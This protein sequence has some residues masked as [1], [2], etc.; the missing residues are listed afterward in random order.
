MLGRSKSPKLGGGRRKLDANLRESAVGSAQARHA[1]FGF[2]L[3]F[4]ISQEKF[5]SDGHFGGENHQSTIVADRD[6]EGLLLEGLLL[7]RFPAD[8]QR[9]VQQIALTASAFGASCCVECVRSYRLWIWHSRSLAGT[10][11]EAWLA[12]P[13][14]RCSIQR[15]PC[16]CKSILV[17]VFSLVRRETRRWFQSSAAC[18]KVDD[19]AC[20]VHVDGGSAGN[21]GKSGHEHHVSRDDHDKTRAGG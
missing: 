4:R 1:S 7:R 3:R 17:C 20:V 12:A 10:L 15:A 21:L 18:S 16:G 6:R 13:S 2:K 5:L 8:D 19:V 9:H 11:R 14:A